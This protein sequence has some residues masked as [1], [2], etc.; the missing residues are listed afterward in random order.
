MKEPLIVSNKFMPKKEE[1]KLSSKDLE[2]MLSE[3]SEVL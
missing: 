1:P 3:E 2:L